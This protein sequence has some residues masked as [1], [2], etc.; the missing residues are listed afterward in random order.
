MYI[1]IN[2]ILVNLKFMN[3]GTIQIDLIKLIKYILR[4]ILLP[5][6]FAVIGFGIL[7]YQTAYRMPNTYTASGT[8]YVYNANPNTLNYQY[9]NTN[10][11]N[12][13]VQLID[14]YMIVVKSNK[15]MDVVAERMSKDY[16]GIKPEF[17]ASTISMASVS[18]TG[19]VR[20]SSVTSEPKLSQDICNA[21]LDAAPE[22]IIR[23]VSAGSVEVIDY[24]EEPTR[25]DP[26]N[27]QN[28]GL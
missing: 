9:T 4:H 14:T 20:V 15:V 28:R 2:N 7:Y 21:V 25:P 19:V 17:I 6:I 13:A 24:A 16:P 22:E 5:I 27:A 23:V 11:L 1:S 3:N 26:R 10:D 18:E 12:S 8:M